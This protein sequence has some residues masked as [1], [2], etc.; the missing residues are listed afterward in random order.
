MTRSLDIEVTRRCNLRCDYCFV[1]WSRDWTSDLPFEVAE[2]V[3]RE[4][5]GRFDLLHLT[6][7]EPFVYKRIFELIDL[8]LSLGFGDVLIN[9]NGTVL[10]DAM[11][12]RL[13]GYGGK[14]GLSI[15]L[16]GPPALHDP[17]RGE[18]RFAQA[19][20]AIAK[21]LDAGVPVTLMTVVTP[22]VLE[23]LPAFMRERY[24]AH[25][26]LKGITLFPVGVGAAGSQKPGKALA[27]LDADAL[28][29][30][31]VNVALA[32]HAGIP[33]TVGAYPIIN[34]L[35]A[36]MGYPASRMYQCS[37]GRGRMCVHADQSVSS[38]HPVK[39]P[40]YGHWRSGLFDTV[41]GVAGHRRLATRDF[42]GCS[43]C[44]HKEACGHCRA[45][46]TSNGAPLYGNDGV[47]L[48]AVPGRREARAQELAQ[49]RA[50]VARP[51]DVVRRLVTLLYEGA[52]ED[53][54]ALIAEDC[55]DHQPA[56]FQPPGALGVGFKRAFWQA[57]APQA[58]SWV[59]ELEEADD[60]A[61]V[62]WKT[63]P[64][65]GAPPLTFRGRLTVRGGRLVEMWVDRVV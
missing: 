55:V 45:F 11:I 58:R 14:V 28:H 57:A 10:T 54:E 63:E 32:W 40:I 22:A 62:L 52:P 3:V 65:P 59:V 7:G 19:D 51:A 12:A 49:A 4:G 25:P 26:R 60:V 39:D 56:P 6:G 9:S 37:A 21:L 15:S 64:A 17:V 30:L 44:S 38:C 50:E 29:V 43:T 47:C 5:A 34:P 61:V 46:V 41:Q 33:V 16:D 18:G 24:I 48:E 2:Q 23:V 36:M 53:F 8:G 42:D 1:G 20:A 13:G 31:A 35:L 27:A